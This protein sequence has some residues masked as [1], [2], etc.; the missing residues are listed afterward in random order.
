MRAA[1]LHR[2]ADR[3]AFQLRTARG[4][5]GQRR[6][7]NPGVHERGARADKKPSRGEDADG[8]PGELEPAAKRLEGAWCV[9][10]RTFD[11]LHLLSCLALRCPAVDTHSTAL[12]PPRATQSPVNHT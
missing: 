1:L 10:R 12:R 8:A 7:G 4:A 11:Y 2:R 3:R 5:D 6:P 9:D